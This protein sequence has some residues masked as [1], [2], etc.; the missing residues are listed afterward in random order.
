[1]PHSVEHQLLNLGMI[2]ELPALPGTPLV[3]DGKVTDPLQTNHYAA[4]YRGRQFAQCVTSLSVGA[5]DSKVYF[6]SKYLNSKID[7]AECNLI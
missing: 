2:V 6:D 4:K 1:M 3:I 7:S 5:N